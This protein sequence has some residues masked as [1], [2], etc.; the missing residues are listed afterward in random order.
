LTNV[1]A[2]HCLTTVTDAEFLPGTVVLLSSFLRHNTWF[3]GDIVVIHRDLPDDSRRLLE[4]FPNVRW[5]QVGAPLLERIEAITSAHPALERKAPIF[6]SL[7]AF[8]L[9]GYDRV[10]KLD[11]DI[12]CTGNAAAL[13]ETNDVLLACPD[14][15]HFRHQT[16]DRITYLPHPSSAGGDPG[17]WATFNAGMLVL[18][19]E[20]LGRDLYPALL[21]DLRPET[22]S[23]VRTKHTDSIVLNR[24]FERTWTPCP[25]RYNYFISKDTAQYTRSRAPLADA[26]FVHF[27]GRRKPWHI[28][29]PL[30]STFDDY[31]VALARWDE[32][33]RV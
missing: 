4:R 13:L 10:L 7:E 29:E 15:P 18:A 11:S 32:A 24:R 5:H 8:N 27:I 14:Q 6:Y 23:T 12:L 16:R 19:P 30:A 17:Q 25:E 22:W 33:A 21:D 3:D 9:C 31:R 1:T 28:R 2:P 26:V 20:R